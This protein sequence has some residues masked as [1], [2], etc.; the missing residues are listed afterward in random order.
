MLIKNEIANTNL[1]TT[2]Y[3]FLKAQ[4][5]NAV[6]KFK[7]NHNEHANYAK[8]HYK[9]QSELHWTLQITLELMPKNCKLECLNLTVSC[10]ETS[11]F[12]RITL[13][14]RI[15]FEAMRDP[16]RTLRTMSGRRTT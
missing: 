11:I 13:N 14:I 6:A 4:L 1:D 3:N 12:K 16:F 7:A 15:A 8:C 10:L 5:R 2:K 9:I